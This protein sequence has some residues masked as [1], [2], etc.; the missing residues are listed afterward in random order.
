MKKKVIFM[1]ISFFFLI[2]PFSFKSYALNE[3]MADKNETVYS[4]YNAND[5]TQTDDGYIWIARYSG[6]VKYNGTDFNSYP[7]APNDK[8]IN[9][10]N[11]MCLLSVNN[12][13]YIG[14]S[15][16]L[17]L[18]QNGEFKIII[19]DISIN[20]IANIDG[21][22]YVA[23]NDGVFLLN[24][25][26]YDVISSKVI[27]SI[28]GNSENIFYVGYDNKVYDSDFNLFYSKYPIKSAAYINQILYLGAIN[29]NVIEVFEEIKEYSLTLKP[30]NH[31]AYY[32]DKLFVAADDGLYRYENSKY[33]KIEGLKVN[34]AIERIK[35]DYQGNL[36]CASSSKGISKISKNSF[37]DVFF[38]YDIPKDNVNAIHIHN[39]LMYIGC[40][41]GL[42]ILD[43]KNKEIVNNSLSDALSGV[44]IRDIETYKNKLYIACHDNENYSLVEYDGN[45][46]NNYNN[47]NIAYSVE[48]TLFKQ[49]RCLDV[50]NDCLYIGTNGGISVFNGNTFSVLNL[51]KMVL[52]LYSD[53]L[54]LYACVKALGVL[55][56]E[57]NSLHY[58]VIEGSTGKTPLKCIT[59]NDELFYSVG[60]ELFY[61][62]NSNSIKLM[63]PTYES[64]VSLINHNNTLFIGSEND[65]FKINSFDE[66]TGE[67]KYEVYG[68][69]NGLNSKITSNGNGYYDNEKGIGYFPTDLGVF[70]L[71]FSSL[72]NNRVAPLIALDEIRVANKLVSKSDSIR[73]SSDSSSINVTFSILNFNNDER[74]NIYYKLDGFDKEYN[75]SSYQT[76]KSISY[77]N[78][79]GGKYKLNIYATD[80]NG[81]VTQNSINLNIVKE[82]GFFE[83]TGVIVGIAFLGVCFLGGVLWLLIRRKLNI[84]IK[85]QNEY[86]AITVEAIEALASTIDAKDKYTNGHS[87][88]VGAYSRIIASE[89]G[90]TGDALENVYYIALLHDVGKIG[91]PLEILNKPDKLTNEEF[92]IMKNHTIL[93]AKIIGS[94]TTIPNIVDGIKYHHERYNGKGYPEGL[95]GENIPFIARLICCADAYDAMSSDRIYRKAL[96]KQRIIQE[97]ENQ[98][99]KQFDPQIARVCIR[100]IKEDRL[101]Y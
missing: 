68:S 32:N 17:V 3:Y 43:E 2:L 10:T 88:R 6:L 76:L 41:N 50:F 79:K 78:L 9:L 84:E 51:N 23:S 83:R 29:G 20:F 15:S 39:D 35:F 97:F 73:I 7:Y 99:G 16:S 60:N 28:V 11:V 89:L 40:E 92:E 49:I 13:L 33:E 54:N 42:I 18:Y 26:G 8:S 1:L 85:R 94:I 56:F 53:D 52:S 4:D 77:T 91:I 44:R 96:D 21:K 64:L 46:I 24:D 34:S 87:L 22:I 70:E 82:Y 59:I 37:V 65:L 38:K 69:S 48:N 72:Q 5:I 63:L 14:T 75:V 61:Y 19:N 62:N 58:E 12:D 98:L 36:W 45:Q 81:N 90:V 30:I 55:K 67:V 86:K 95:S 71:S 25:N 101:K 100:L 27:I 47:V 31:F 93:G 57:K 66:T 80:V 74:F